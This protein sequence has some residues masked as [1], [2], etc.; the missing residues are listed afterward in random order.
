MATFAVLLVHGPGWDA[1]RSIRAQDGWDE[2]AAFFDGLVESGF[3]ILGGPLGG[4]ERTLHLIDAADAEEIR[5]RLRQ[6]PWASAGLLEV[7]SIETWAL[8]LDSRPG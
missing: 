8:W 7:A 3:E 4:G 6:D 5:A 2:H 1:S